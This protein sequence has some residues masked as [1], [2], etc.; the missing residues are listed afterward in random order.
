MN[1]TIRKELKKLSDKSYAGFTK[2]L[3]PGLSKELLGVRLPLLRKMAKDLVKN[4]DYHFYLKSKDEKYMEEVMLKGLIIGYGTAREGDI[5]EALRLLDEF[6]GQ[7]DN[8]SV[9][10]FFCTSFTIVE[11]HREEVFNHLKFFLQFGSEY[12]VRLALVLLLNYYIRLDVDGNKIKRRRKV[13]LEDLEKEGEEFNPW[14]SKI[15]GEID[16]DFGEDYY[17]QM[18]AGWFLSEAFNVYPYEVY[19]FLTDKEKRYLNEKT[20][21]LVLKKIRESRIPSKEVK[22]YLTEKISFEKA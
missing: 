20:Y 12:I 9:C 2:K 22:E 4:K 18:A 11:N 10:D 7:I 5:K 3:I 14:L 13:Q 17:A 1:L 6:A 15:L 19:V 8:W 16:R 21:S